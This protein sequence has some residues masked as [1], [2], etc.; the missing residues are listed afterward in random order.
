MVKLNIQLSRV[1]CKDWC[2]KNL[3][4]DCVVFQESKDVTKNQ[5]E[6]FFIDC[7]DHSLLDNCM[8]IPRLVETV[9]KEKSSYVLYSMHF[10][11]TDAWLIG[12]LCTLEFIAIA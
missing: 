9:N 8:R 6:E 4:I 7:H 1:L 2:N 10:S 11:E 3:K 12:R 5:I